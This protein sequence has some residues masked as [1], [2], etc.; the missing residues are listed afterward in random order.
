MALR[1]EKLPTVV[2][3]ANAQQKGQRSEGADGYVEAAM[4]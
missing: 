2:I 1:R 4:R 3:V